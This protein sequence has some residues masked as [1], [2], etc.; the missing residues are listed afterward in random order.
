MQTQ[1]EAARNAGVARTDAKALK[2]R[3]DRQLVL[4]ALAQHGGSAGISVPKLKLRLPF[5]KETVAQHLTELKK[6]A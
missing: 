3:E 2:E 5:A 4:T 1:A 6:A